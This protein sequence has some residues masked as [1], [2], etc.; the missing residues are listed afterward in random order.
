MYK[1]PWIPENRV[2]IEHRREFRQGATTVERASAGAGASGVRGLGGSAA[3]RRHRR[4]KATGVRGAFSVATAAREVRC[5]LRA[6]RVNVR[7]R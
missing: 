7:A 5:V 3:R 2:Q 4:P 1:N 6:S